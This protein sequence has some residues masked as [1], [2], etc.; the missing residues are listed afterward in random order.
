MVH[1]VDPMYVLAI[2]DS[3]ELIAPKVSTVGSIDFPK[4]EVILFV[5]SLLRETYAEIL[6][7]NSKLADVLIVKVFL[8]I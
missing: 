7:S 4:G 5:K 3:K 8:L 1:V 2:A 6:K